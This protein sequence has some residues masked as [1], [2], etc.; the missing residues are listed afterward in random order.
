MRRATHGLLSAS[1]ATP[2]A[3]GKAQPRPS[4]LSYGLLPVA[5]HIH[6]VRIYSSSSVVLREHAAQQARQ[7]NHEDTR[8]TSSS[9]HDDKSDSKSKYDEVE[10]DGQLDEKLGEQAEKQSRTPWHREGADQP[11]VQRRRS[12]GA[13]TKGMHVDRRVLGM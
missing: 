7:Q 9:G 1:I 8:T 3:L 13:M 2:S 4:F 6:T 11:P 12:A 5:H 10:Y